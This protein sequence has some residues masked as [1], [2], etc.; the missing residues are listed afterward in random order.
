M[1]DHI[2]AIILGIIEGVTEFLPISSTGHMLLVKDLLGIDL[3]NDPFWKLFI[4]VIQFGAILSVVWFFRKKLLE[5]VCDF[6][7]V[8]SVEVMIKHPLFI[9]C[10]AVVPAGLAGLLL[11][12]HI[13]TLM[14]HTLPIALALIVGGILMEWIERL[15]QNKGS[16][17]DVKHVSLRASCMIGCAQVVSMIPG[18][19]RSGATIMGGLLCGLNRKT[20]TEFSFLLSIPTMTAAS[21]YSLYKHTAAI[22]SDQW[23]TL[24]IGF[25]T[26]FIVALCVVAWF[27]KF[28]Q[29]HRFRLFIVY[30]IILGFLII[31]L[32]SV[33]VVT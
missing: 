16:V 1:S 24:T 13:D 23:V 8:R 9:V 7:R 3:E 28:V 11:K 4:I 29:S 10:L 25:V 6:L 5:L 27:L 17:T 22:S 14:E 19:S 30:R 20:A 21:S 15:T 2:R 32:W 31:G 26:S 33:G 18:V 12:K